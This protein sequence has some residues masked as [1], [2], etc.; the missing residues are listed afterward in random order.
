MKPGPLESDRDTIEV[1]IARLR[2]AT[3]TSAHCTPA[4]RRCC[5]VSHSLTCRATYKSEVLPGEQPGIVDWD[6]FEAVQVKLNAQVN[7]HKASRLKSEALFAGRIF[8]D[9]GHRITPSHARNGRQVPVLHLLCSS[10]ER[11]GTG[12]HRQPRRGR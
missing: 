10:A 12:R 3:S 4:G 2:C 6:L 9:R 1:E 8:D 7:N 11:P 5:G